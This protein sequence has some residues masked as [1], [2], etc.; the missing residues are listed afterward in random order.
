[1]RSLT[2]LLNNTRL[3][4]VKLVTAR[5]SAAVLLSG[6]LI[7]LVVSIGAPLLTAV[8]GRGDG[9]AEALLVGAFPLTIIGPIVGALVVTPG[10]QYRDN[11]TYFI[12]APSRVSHLVAQFLASIACA[13]AMSAVALIAGITTS[14]LLAMT[15]GSGLP[16]VAS[17]VG[18]TVALG[19][20]S[21]IAGVAMASVLLSLPLT[22][23]FI[24]VQ[25]L[26]LDP[27]LSFAPD[28]GVYFQGSALASALIG[29]GPAV[30]GISSGIVW[31]LLP[32][33]LGFVRQRQYDVH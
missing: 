18:V 20:T 28:W 7:I 8:Q 10:W 25:T 15:Q 13:L 6:L 17:P 4:L 33:A 32:A 26:V 23:V 29:E 19:V 22:L 21:T 30:A 3:E 11:S 31:I 14:G 2:T 1:M 16:D 9:Y 24:L 12:V 5:G 27:V